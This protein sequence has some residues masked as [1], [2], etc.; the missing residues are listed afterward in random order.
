ME[1]GS[2]IR[3][4]RVDFEPCVFRLASFALHLTSFIVHP[5]SEECFSNL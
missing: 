2:L 4:K 1:D 3:F 5:K